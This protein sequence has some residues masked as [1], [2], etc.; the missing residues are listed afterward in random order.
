[1]RGG[2]VD[3]WKFALDLLKSAQVAVV[4][5][6]AFGPNGEGHIRINFGRSEEDINEA[7]DRIENYF[8]IS[9]GL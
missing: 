4:P 1:M 7:M 2:E 5:G 3:S 9:Q 6:I 8:K